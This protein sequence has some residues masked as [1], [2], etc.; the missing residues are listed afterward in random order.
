MDA[1]WIIGAKAENPVAMKLQVLRR[2]NLGDCKR[3]CSTTKALR[4]ERAPICGGGPGSELSTPLSGADTVTHHGPV[5]LL[6]MRLAVEADV[7]ARDKGPEDLK[8]DGDVVE[9]HP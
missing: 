4:V 1:A 5:Q 3:G 6:E 7:D 2:R 9:A 8:H